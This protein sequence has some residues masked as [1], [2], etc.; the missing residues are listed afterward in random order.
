VR[1]TQRIGLAVLAVA[2][3]GL[4]VAVGEPAGS[5]DPLPLRRVLLTSERLPAELKRVRDGVLVQLGRAEFEERLR[6]AARAVGRVAPRLAEARYRA[7]LR[8]VGGNPALIGTGQWTVAYAGSG[9]GLLPL[10]PFNLALRQARFENRD[11]LV[12]D[13]DGRGPALLIDEAGE[14][15]LAIEWSARGEVRPEGVQFDLLAPPCPVA[16]LEVDVPADRAV[17]AL[18]GTPVSGPH[19]AEAGDRRLWKVYCGGRSQL[20]VLVRPPAPSSPPL[21]LVRQRT[22]QRLAPEG[23]EAVYELAVEALHP[24]VREL[25]CECDPELRPREVSAPGLEGWDA[26][27]AAPGQ[28]T[29]LA[30]RLSEPLREGTVQVSCLAPLGPAPANGPGPI[31]VVAWHS[32]TVRLSGAVPRGETLEVWLHPDLRFE[33]WQPGGFRLLSAGAADP[34]RRDSDGEPRWQRLTLS[35]GGLEAHMRPAARLRVRGADFRARQLAWWQVGPGTMSLSLHIVYEVESG[36]LFQLAVLLPVGWEPERVEVSPAGLLRSWGVQQRAGRSTLL[37]D[38]QRPLGTEE[39]RSLPR[40]RP[41]EGPG[42]SA[43]EMPRRQRARAPALTVQLRPA[44]AG[45]LAGRDLPFP[46]PVPLG[47]RLHEG[48]LAVDVDEQTYQATVRAAVEPAEPEDDGPWGKRHPDYY[49]RFQGDSVRGTLRLAPRPPRLRA[50]CQSEVAVTGGRAAMEMQVLLEAE[51]GS[52]DTVDVL[53]SAP[54]PLRWERWQSLRDQATAAGATPVRRAERQPAAEAV[55]ALAALAARDSLQA[56]ALLAVRPRAQRW[57]LTLAR[58][59]KVRELL[60]LSASASLPAAQRGWEVPLPVVVG[61]ERM[62]GEVTLQLAGADRVQVEAAG[63]REVPTPS[64]PTAWRTYRYGAAGVRL[65]LRGQTVAPTVP[66]VDRAALTT[67]LTG[68][69]VLQHHFV[70]ETSGWPEPVL[71][72]HLPAGA[73][74]RAVGVDGHW[75]E[76]QPPAA[77]ANQGD[78]PMVLVPVPGRGDDRPHRIEVV[79]TTAAGPWTAWLP[80]QRLEAPAPELPLRPATFRR[81]W[82]LPPGVL[83][84]SA[85]RHLC[86]SAGPGHSLPPAD[87]ALT[88]LYRLPGLPRPWP[89]PAGDPDV[90]R[91]LNN[92]ARGLRLGPAA[93]LPLFEVIDRLAFRFLRDR[94]ALVLDTAALTEAGLAANTAVPLS[95]PEGQPPWEAVGLVVVP[96]R[97]AVLVT[98]RSQLDAW[99]H[100]GTDVGLSA[101]LPAAGESA[102]DGPVPAAVE[103]ALAAA[104]AAGQDPSGRFQA[105]LLWLRPESG[106]DRPA[107][108][109]PGLDLPAWTEWEPVPGAESASLLVL[110]TASVTAAGL[111]VIAMLAVLAWQLRRRSWR[112]RVTLLLAGLAAL[113]LALLFL[114]AALHD[115]AF[116]PLLA[117]CAVGLIWYLRVPSPPVRRPQRTAAAGGTVAVLLLGAGLTQTAQGPIGP[118]PPTPTTVYLLP[119]EGGDPDRQAVLVPAALLERLKALSQGSPTAEAVLLSALYEGKVE[120]TAAEFAAVFAAH[121][122]G[123]GPATLAVPLDGVQI[124][125]DVWVDGARAHPVTLPAPQAGYALAVKGRGRHKVEMRF[126]VAVARTAADHGVQFTVPPL[127]QS[128][129]VLR[130]PAEAAAPLVQ[131]AHG[132]WGELADAAGRRLEADLG[133]LTAPLAIRWLPEARPAAASV[134]YRAAYLWDL[135]G[136]ASTLQAFVHC[137][138]ARGA[139]T[140]LAVKMPTELEV[141]SAQVHRSEDAPGPAVRLK[142]YRVEGAG[143]GRLLRLEFAAP[144]AGAFDVLLELVPRGPLPAKLTLPVPEPQAEPLPGD[145][146]LAYRTQGIEAVAEDLQRVTGIEPAE[147]APFW[148]DSSRPPSHTLSYAC[149][150]RRDPILRLQLRPAAVTFDADQE[151]VLRVGPRRAQVQAT[152]VLTAPGRDLAFIEWEC[153]PALPLSVAAVRGPD[154]HH[155]SQEGPRLRVWLERAVSSTRL[156]LEGWLPLAGDGKGPARLLD[157]PCLRLRRSRQQHTAVRLEAAP[158]WVLVPQTPQHLKPAAGPGLA[159]ESTEKDYALACLVRPAAAAASARVLVSTFVREDELAFTAVVEYRPQG[160]ELRSAQVVLRHW[161]GDKVRLNPAG[162]ARRR[163]RRRAATERSWLLELPPGV[164]GPYRLTLSG[165]VPLEEATSGMLLPEV[166]VPGVQAVES[167]VAVGAGLAAQGQGAVRPTGAVPG[168]VREEMRHGEDGAWQVTGPECQMRVLPVTA[169]PRLFLAEQS[170]AVA[171]QRRWVHEVV[172]WLW[173]GGLADLTVRLPA[174]A[175][176]VA[177]AVDGV[178]W[179]PLQPGPDSLWLPLPGRPGLRQVRLRWLYQTPE[180]LERPDLA[181]PRLEGLAPG[182]TLWTAWVP[183][184]SEMNLPRPRAQQQDMPEFLGKGAARQAALDLY[185]AQEQLEALG[186]LAEQGRGAEL[187]AGQRRFAQWCTHAERALTVGAGKG[188]LRGPSGQ[189]LGDWLLGLRNAERALAQRPRFEELLRQ[190]ERPADNAAEE[191]VTVSGRQTAVPLLVRGTPVSW[192]GGPGSAPPR[193]RLVPADIGRDEAAGAAA[194]RWLALLGVVW[195]AAMLPFLAGLVRRSWPEQMALVGMWG[196]YQVGPMLVVLFLIALGVCGRLLLLGRGVLHL[197]RRKP[198]RAPST[199]VPAA[200]VGS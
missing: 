144:V 106:D 61:A 70:F 55:G 135:R 173:Q 11:A 27:P 19:P 2:V 192:R 35:G 83:P 67:Y 48:A 143:G 188:G 65:V 122:P 38:L 147:F 62:E 89:I 125:G 59:L 199:A 18:D 141:R 175:R 114:P 111:M 137:Q 64:R 119:T 3:S 47:A 121:C 171:D 180:P 78:R 15:A 95:G 1:W 196:W 142:D 183:A 71:P 75:L 118:V 66:A 91:A 17:A 92:A 162:A 200:R 5:G 36:Q 102:G 96:A 81:A 32:P 194:A 6:Q 150:V 100:A 73:R 168:W 85:E 126:R 158:E 80:W 21:R 152:A 103:R 16:V 166:S 169:P 109:A 190:A 82:R 30:I 54:L 184:G 56:V 8:D 191:G 24:G 117:G 49:Y 20:N 178:E 99:Q 33:D 110:T 159:Y 108:T 145:H 101:L 115:L 127:V 161:P 148:P 104:V 4:S 34:D 187:V 128:R 46:D 116:W 107:A 7:A 133:R 149:A 112:L 139:A 198:R 76:R 45:R 163:E 98:T 160:T 79:Y 10:Q 164:N 41:S 74:L 167:W 93:W 138:V 177:V 157:V 60:W 9:P 172:W 88:D 84:L 195:V 105:A 12:A 197:F 68:D 39:F 176:V 181:S 87:S 53:L 90:L 134:K 94:A 136:D 179:T 77:V 124:V 170:A 28:P 26:P 154:V 44:E 25:V 156:E 23:I 185:R 123:D 165:E 97:T 69:G 193:L 22:V 63:L 132:A 182:V 40:L 86:L 29:R 52:T 174:Q 50:Q 37:V 186:V 155:W 153:R 189:A 146:H 13:F 43:H 14:H 120:G 51:A 129:L 31:Q 140:S 42:E 113:G 131:V 58:P 130:L 57:R 72:L 151:V